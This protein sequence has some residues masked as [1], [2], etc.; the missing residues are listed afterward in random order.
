MDTPSPSFTTCRKIE[1][2]KGDVFAHSQVSLVTPNPASRGERYSDGHCYSN[3]GSATRGKRQME[4]KRQSAIKMSHP[5]RRRG[6][7]YTYEW[8]EN[9]GR[10]YRIVMKLNQP[11]FGFHFKWW[12][13]ASCIYLC[14]QEVS[15]VTDI[16]WLTAALQQKKHSL[17]E[18]TFPLKSLKIVVYV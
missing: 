14:M 11:F 15:A 4:E 2:P 7:R 18:L 17:L 1:A 9:A 8:W 3:R 13:N 6:S 16:Q 10:E 12:N 5:G